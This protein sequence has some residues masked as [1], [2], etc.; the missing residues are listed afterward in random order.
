MSVLNVSGFSSTLPQTYPVPSQSH[1]APKAVDLLK[2]NTDL[3]SRWT[4]PEITM[5]IY[6]GYPMMK[7]GP[8]FHLHGDISQTGHGV[9]RVGFASI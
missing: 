1:C 5:R 2:T 4:D 7:V 9:F 3:I 8:M 6:L